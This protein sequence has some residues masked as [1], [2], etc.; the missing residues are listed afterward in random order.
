MSTPPERGS[1]PPSG[2]PARR[3]IS[4]LRRALA[5]RRRQLAL[6]LGSLQ[7]RAR[8]EEVELAL[9]M[10]RATGC[11]A[12]ASAWV[13]AWLLGVWAFGSFLVYADAPPGQRVEPSFVQSPR[14]TG[15]PSPATPEAALEL[16]PVAGL[17]RDP[18]P[19]RLP[20]PYPLDDRSR[21][22]GPATIACPAVEL[23]DHAGD[24]IAFDP[25]ARVAP[26]F[27]ERLREL[28]RV[29]REVS[30]PFYGRP[31]SALLIA[32][33]YDCRSI[34]GSRQR[35][36][37]HALG[38]AID[39]TGFRFDTLDPASAPGF[40]VRIDRHWKAHGDATRELHARFLEAITQALIARDVFRTLLGPAHR[41]HAD[42]FHFDVAPH[43]YVNL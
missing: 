33:S 32:S 29:L 10:R 11:L 31:P 7:S 26:P 15:R 17:D 18:P 25:P 4:S 1:P 41:D 35:L 36:S 21:A 20:R 30:A 22:V 23:I 43:Y 28:E 37:E 38:N 16:E 12:F 5:A 9:G 39:I 2:S 6:G 24:S 13:G 42:H 34:S 3:A 40:E 19:P 8:R 14:A 27:R